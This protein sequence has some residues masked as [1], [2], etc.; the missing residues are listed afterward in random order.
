M[1]ETKIS[2]LVPAHGENEGF[3]ICLNAILNISEFGKLKFLIGHITILVLL[4]SAVGTK[5]R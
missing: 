4:F 5:G 2:E 3:P 1:N